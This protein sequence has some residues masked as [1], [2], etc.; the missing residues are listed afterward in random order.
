MLLR[1]FSF[2]Y[3]L[4][5]LWFG[6]AAYLLSCAGLSA[7]SVGGLVFLPGVIMPAL[8]AIA[9]TARSE[10]RAGVWQL[11]G[12]IVQWRVNV[13]YYAFAAG[14]MIA[15]KLAGAL[16]Y[17][18]AFDIWPVF[19]ALPWYVIAVAVL[20]S[21]P[22]QAGEE[23][24]WRGYALPQLTKRFGLRGASI[25]LGVIWAAWHLPFFFIPGGDNI[26]QSFPVYVIA[27]IGISVAMAWLYWKTNQ[28]LLL[29]M[30]MHAS[31]DNTAGIVT[32][33]VPATVNNPFS[34]PHAALPWIVA[35]L[36]CLSGAWFLVKMRNYHG[37][38]PRLHLPIFI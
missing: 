9:M 4:S 22:V 15:I 10:G 2:T 28:S 5:W 25:I 14:Y 1:Y 36:I 12:G 34:L 20:I 30:L 35:T 31:I 37:R 8:V 21:T 19:G 24:G 17:R 6:A 7:S 33:P 11:L 13:W 26:G 23:V 16:I 32:S 29:V 18:I 38:M 27:V 3:V